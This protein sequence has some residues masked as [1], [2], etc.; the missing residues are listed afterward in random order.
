MMEIRRLLLLIL[1][2]S[3]TDVNIVNGFVQN[4]GYTVAAFYSKVAPTQRQYHL[5]YQSTT[6]VNSDVILDNNTSSTTETSVNEVEISATSSSRLPHS[7]ISEQTRKDFT[8]LNNRNLGSASTSDDDGRVTTPLIYFDSAATSQKPEHV[9]KVMNDYYHKCNANVHRGA[10]T[11]SREATEA[12]EAA[13]DTVQHFIHAKS[14]NEIIFT[15]GA[16][17]AINIIAYSYGR[18]FL[19]EGDEILLTVAEHHSN[20]V[21]WQII[22]AEKGL[23]LKFVNVVNG[24]LDIDHMESLL[25]DKTKIMSFQHV[26]NVLGCINPVQDIVQKVR[27]HASPQCKIVLDACQSI[28]HMPVNVDDLGIDFLAASGHKMCGPTGI[29]FLWGHEDILNT[30]PPFKGGGEM[31]D[32]VTLTS[33][34]WQLAPGRFEAGTPPIAQAIGLGAAIDYLN[35]IGMDQINAYEHELGEYLYSRLSIIPGI[36]I[37]GP[38]NPKRRAALCAFSH[39]TVHPSDLSTFLDIE[40]VAV[41]SGHHCCQPLHKSLGISH[42]TRASLYFY[43]TKE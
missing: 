9:L 40:G 17:D 25:T 15:S 38:T 12:Y 16:T 31:I 8:I 35:T 26:S 7:Y 1:P 6:P 20:L 19:H 23:V 42:S 36:T 30:M 13:R 3:Y 29:G 32:E 39:D 28:P 2:L 41:R 18:G 34:T 43:N 4:S 14:R 27:L 22:A 5:L 10:H 24:E 11:L 33:S 21:P 37:L